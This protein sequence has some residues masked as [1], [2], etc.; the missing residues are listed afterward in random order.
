MNPF[1]TSVLPAFV[2][3]L[4]FAPPLPDA[5]RFALPRE[6]EAA[7]GSPCAAGRVS[8]FPGRAGGLQRAVLLGRPVWIRL[9]FCLFPFFIQALYYG[10][11]RMP[12]ACE[13][14]Y[15]TSRNYLCSKAAR[16]V[17]QGMPAAAH[18]L[19]TRPQ[20]KER[21]GEH[22]ARHDGTGA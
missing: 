8:S 18:A 5:F 11:S 13:S 16:H 22:D 9:E 15:T 6:T 2:L 4:A 19:R 12:H 10:E 17:P 7:F 20:M 21:Q 1:A 3:R 14:D